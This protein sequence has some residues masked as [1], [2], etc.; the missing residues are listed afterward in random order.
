MTVF[1]MTLSEAPG[2]VM[3]VSAVK[4]TTCLPSRLAESCYESRDAR[5]IRT[6]LDNP[7]SLLGSDA[8]PSIMIQT[9]RAQKENLD[10]VEG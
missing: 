9:L 10:Y 5:L 3:V 8:A 4:T 1:L 7:S 6:L 2:D